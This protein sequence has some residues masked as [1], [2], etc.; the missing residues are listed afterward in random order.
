MSGTYQIDRLLEATVKHHGRELRLE[1]GRTPRVYVD[2]TFKSIGLI[3][4]TP[5]H[6]ND[7]VSSVLSEQAQIDLKATGRASTNF[8]F[9]PG[10]RLHAIATH[11]NGN[12]TLLIRPYE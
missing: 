7:F 11:D 3:V 12:V 1:P 4:L 6:I 8:E 2:R 9:G 10:V 5:D